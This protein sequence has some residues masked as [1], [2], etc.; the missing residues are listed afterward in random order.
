M[1]PH[2]A[3]FEAVGLIAA[4]LTTLSFLPQA[5]RIWRTRSARD[6][7]LAMYLMMTTGTLMWLAYGLLIGSLAL[8]VSNLAGFVM[9]ASVLAL[10]VN[11]MLRPRNLLVE[12][13]EAEAT[14]IIA[15]PVNSNDL[16]PSEVPIAAA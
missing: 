8:I 5:L 12:I 11:D 7:S 4:C 14:T 1:T 13:V 10:K 6:V 9:V 2:N 16:L 3:W 15:E